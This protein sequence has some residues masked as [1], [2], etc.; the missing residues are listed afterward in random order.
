MHMHNKNEI[1]SY[2]I[3]IDGFA[4]DDDVHRLTSLYFLRV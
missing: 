3:Q 2:N 4:T 1:Q